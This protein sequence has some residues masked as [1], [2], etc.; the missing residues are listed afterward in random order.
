MK[1]I[2]KIILC[3]MLILG[4]SMSFAKGIDITKVELKTL[5]GKEYQLPKGKKTYLKAWAS[6]CPICLSSLEELDKF[7]A[8]EDRIEIVSVVFPGK[9]GEMKLDEF[10]SWYNSLGYKNIKVLVDEKGELLKLARIR[11]YPTSIFVNEVGEIEGVLPGQIPKEIVLKMI[12]VEGKKEEKKIDKVVTQEEKADMKPNLKEIYLAGGCFWGVEAYMERVPG[13]VDAVSGYANGNTVNPKYE[14]VI[15][16]GT[17]HAETVKVTYDS[18]KISLD[19]LL[20][21]YFRIIDPTSLNK[22]GNDR[23]KQYR[24]GIYYTDISDEKVVTEALKNLQERFEKKVV[25]ENKK[26]ENFYLAEEYHQDYLKKNPNGYC[27]IDLNKA[28]EVLI[29]PRKYPKLSEEELKKK[30]SEK[31]YRIT[32]MNDTELA[33]D[34]EYWNFFEPGL[35]VDITTGEP[36]FLSN[37][38][39]DSMC[40][41]PSFTKPINSDVVTYH[42]DTSYNMVRIEVRSRS[43]NAHLGHVFDDGPRDRGGLRYCINSGALNFIPLAE[44]EKEGYGYLVPLVKEF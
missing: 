37:D 30:L 34:N 10:K 24:T 6:W 43:G 31:Q 12:G 26:L 23:G 16:K 28:E 14:D 29:D 7:T 8:E 18:N 1:F 17:G 44:M 35:Y 13:V 27:H 38:K 15:Y 2:K 21:H 20:Q 19:T 42:K 25:V 41:W 9:S 22:Q 11:A 39:Y 36:L 33:F 4:G 40:G 3:L 5:D 32:Q